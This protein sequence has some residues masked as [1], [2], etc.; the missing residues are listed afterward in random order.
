[1]DPGL[2]DALHRGH[3]SKEELRHCG[4]KG[5]AFGADGGALAIVVQVFLCSDRIFHSRA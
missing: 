1:M 2:G 3:L 4:C 5:I